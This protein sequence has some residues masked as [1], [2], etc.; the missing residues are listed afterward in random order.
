MSKPDDVC[1]PRKS[2]RRL[3]TWIARAFV[4][5]WISAWTTATRARAPL[6]RDRGREETVGGEL[7]ASGPISP[8]FLP[9]GDR[10]RGRRRGRTK[11]K[12]HERYDINGRVLCSRENVI[13]QVR[14]H[15]STRFAFIHFQRHFSS[16]SLSMSYD[17]V[18]CLSTTVS[19]LKKI[20]FRRHDVFS[21]LK[22]KARK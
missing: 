17:F 5:A 20:D 12:G 22:I 1:R 21:P 3:L 19:S 6:W 15:S 2:R 11:V 9:S 13:L 7:S 4:F 14:A 8:S 18:R 10:G 16:L